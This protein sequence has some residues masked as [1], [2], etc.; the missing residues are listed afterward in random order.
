MGLPLN[1]RDNSGGLLALPYCCSQLAP[2]GGL[3]R[4]MARVSPGIAVAMALAGGDPSE[5]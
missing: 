4:G 2:S 5:L 1:K 3:A